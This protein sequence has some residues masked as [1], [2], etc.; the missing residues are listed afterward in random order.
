MVAAEIGKAT[1]AREGRNRRSPRPSHLHL[2]QLYRYTLQLEIEDLSS[3][4][5][6]KTTV[7]SDE[8][9]LEMD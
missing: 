7:S 1:A 4:H 9:G 8:H 5:A 3:T 2:K 6:I